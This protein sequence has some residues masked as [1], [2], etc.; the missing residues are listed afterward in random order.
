MQQRLDRRD[1]LSES[2]FLAAAAALAPAAGSLSAAEKAAAARKGSANDRLRVAVVGVRGRG[3]SHVEGFTNRHN[4]V[5]TT[6]C[7]ADSAV[8]GN[9]MRHVEREQGKAPKYEQDVR[10]VVADKDIDIVA[11]ATPNHWHALMAIWAMQNGKDVY[12]EKPVSHNVLEGR[13]I[14][15]AAQVRQDLPDR[16]AEPQQQGHA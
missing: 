7:D 5:V 3:M 4:C 11:I 8:I 12:V 6:V 16:H 14:V 2:A 10:K 1:F 15:E 13:R 9:A